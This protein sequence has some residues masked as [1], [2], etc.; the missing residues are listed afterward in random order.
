MGDCSQFA[1]PST[2]GIEGSKP[3][4]AGV[5]SQVLLHM[6]QILLM[7]Q[8]LDFCS[9]IESTRGTLDLGHVQQ[10]L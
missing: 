9:K 7:P 4:D 6:P 8:L 1:V 3:L 10:T 5:A 2:K